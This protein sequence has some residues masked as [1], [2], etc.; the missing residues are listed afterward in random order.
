MRMARRMTMTTPPA[1]SG[2]GWSNGTAPQVSFPS[3]SFSRPVGHPPG[4]ARICLRDRPRPGRQLLAQD[5]REKIVI[6]PIERE[7]LINQPLFGQLLVSVPR[8]NLV[9]LPHLG[10]PGVEIRRGDHLR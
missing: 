6:D 3:M 10:Q 2:I 7:G 4:C 5:V 9:A 8:Q 1:T